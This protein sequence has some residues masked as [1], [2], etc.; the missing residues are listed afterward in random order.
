MM[1]VPNHQVYLRYI[2]H[3]LMYTCVFG[4]FLYKFCTLTHIHT[5]IVVY[6]ITLNDRDVH[7]HSHSNRPISL[8]TSY[9]WIHMSKPSSNTGQIKSCFQEIENG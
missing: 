4:F 5:Y 8:P 3:V 1:K 6:D 9:L 7:L 2:L